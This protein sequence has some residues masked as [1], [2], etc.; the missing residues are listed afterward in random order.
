MDTFC[1]VTLQQQPHLVKK[2]KSYVTYFFFFCVTAWGYNRWYRHL[3]GK[4]LDCGVKNV[5]N[6]SKFVNFE[7][8]VCL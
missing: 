5:K 3:S 7:T 4:K 6:E 8:K 1:L 2:T